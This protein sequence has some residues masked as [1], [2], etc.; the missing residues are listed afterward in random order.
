MATTYISATAVSDVPTYVSGSEPKEYEFYSSSGTIRAY[1]FSDEEIKAGKRVYLVLDMFQ[2]WVYSKQS[3]FVQ[4]CAE[5]G[6]VQEPIV[7]SPF[8]SIKPDFL[9]VDEYGAL[10]ESDAR[11]QDAGFL[12]HLSAGTMRIFGKPYSPLRG[13]SLGG[14]PY[15]DDDGEPR[16]MPRGSL[17]TDRTGVPL[18]LQQRAIGY[19]EDKYAMHS[20]FYLKKDADGTNPYLMDLRTDSPYLPS[21]FDGRECGFD[22][23]PIPRLFA[24]PEEWEL[25]PDWRHAQLSYDLTVAP[26]AAAGEAFVKGEVFCF[27]RRV[28]FVKQPKMDMES[29]L[30]ELEAA[31]RARAD[32]E[33]LEPEDRGPEPPIP[34]TSSMDPWV[35]NAGYTYWELIV[36]EK[37][38]E[39]VRGQGDTDALY[40]RVTEDGIEFFG[41]EAALNAVG[42]I[43][44]ARLK[45]AKG[46]GRPLLHSETT[47]CRKCEYAPSRGIF[48]KVDADGVFH[49]VMVTPDT[50]EGYGLPVARI[51]KSLNPETGQ[52]TDVVEHFL[53]NL[54]R[55][56]NELMLT[57]E[58]ECW[59]LCEHITAD[60]AP[61][62]GDPRAVGT[63][64]VFIVRDED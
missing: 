31:L 13:T 54:N 17:R 9:G 20:D 23:K 18:Y 48:V 41:V 42:V 14:E 47:V 63:R 58:H 40:L 24:F 55:V 56:G 29:G 45:L 27:A 35:Q 22:I 44:H 61:S 53:Y 28:S 10:E 3:S 34:D 64:I 46:A 43:E 21:Y 2:R 52:C 49:P 6:E 5:T 26:N 38:Y 32:W 51:H 19:D 36:P 37:Y 30:T 62:L 39:G 1:N 7:G 12:Y 33:A 11:S 4:L 59:K 8:D 50:S 15:I 16:I 25:T 57:A 60:R